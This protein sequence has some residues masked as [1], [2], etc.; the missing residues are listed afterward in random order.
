MLTIS[1]L[2]LPNTSEYAA[3]LSLR[4]KILREYPKIE[5][6]LTDNITIIVGAKCHGQSVRD[7]DIVVFGKFDSQ[8]TF[9]PF[10]PFTTHS[11]SIERPDSIILDS[12]C[13]AIEVKAHSAERVRFVGSRVEVFYPDRQEWHDASHQNEMQKQSLLN[14]LRLLG[15]DPI[16]WITPLLWMINVPGSDLPA[17]PHNILGSDARWSLFLNVIAQMS[18]PRSVERRWRLSANYGNE[19][20]INKAVQI[21][22]KTIRPTAIDRRRMEQ[23]NQRVAEEL[24]LHTL[25]GQ[26]LLIL[27]GRGGSGKT[28]RLL[29]LAKHLYDDTARRV[30]I[31]TYNRALVADL[32]RLLTIMGISDGIADRSIQIQTVQSFFYTIL[33]GLGILS[34]TE[35]NFLDNYVDFKN[36]ALLMLTAGAVQEDDVKNLMRSHRLKFSWDY[37][38]ID[39]AQDFPDDERDIL[40]RLYSYRIFAVA[41]G[42]DQLIRSQIPADWRGNLSVSDIHTATLKTCLRMKA[43]L[44]QFIGALAGELGLQESEW[45]A[46][47]NVPGGRIIIIEGINALYDR[48]Q[49]ESWIDQTRQ[50]GNEPV[51]MLFCVPPTMVRQ[52]LGNDEAAYSEIAKQFRDWGWK[53]WD[54]ASFAI[55]GTYPT[56]N[57]ELRIVQYDSCRG[58]EGWTVVLLGLD[59]FYTYKLKQLAVSAGIGNPSKVQAARWL[60][61]P[62]TRAMDTLIIHITEQASPV[63]DALRAVANQFSDIVEWRTI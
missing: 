24:H 34:G 5:N 44:T 36:E 2:T 6:S 42:I 47:E 33:Q 63:R 18:P 22:T 57:D 32:R 25:V 61:I 9:R 45:V 62:L 43:G 46:N 7:I 16:P 23:I 35:E 20:N 48:T 54:G 27:R 11:G 58:L 60:L 56:D 53:V 10:L 39:E 31:L 51:D 1:G 15:I 52:S 41:D 13:L 8:V 14:Y 21:L 55:R 30:L 50:A 17:R 19:T 37:I 12:F 40:F 4:E 38:F 3:A 26:K 59:E 28:M 49:F 29:Q